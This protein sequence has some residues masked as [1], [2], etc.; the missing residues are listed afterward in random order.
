MNEDIHS[1]AGAF[2]LDALS[3]PERTRFEDHLATCDDCA[4]EVRGLREAA[5]HLGAAVAT[6]APPR[7]RAQTL[8]RIG[9]VRQLP[10][11][12]VADLGV[13]RE[14]RARRRPRFAFSLAAA[15]LVI[16]LISGVFAIR[17]QQELDRT[18]AAN[19]AVA[20]VLSSPDARTVSATA[21]TGGTATVVVSRSSGR[22]VFASSGLKPLPRSQ[23]YEL[24][25]MTSQSA[26]PAGLVRP[27]AD[28][29]TRP[30]VA[31]DLRDATQVG[32]TVEPEDGSPQPTADPILVLTL[33]A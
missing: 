6:A 19:V 22:I 17:S 11:A 33:P 30:V 4:Q 32:V 3:D 21:Q 27:G 7:L 18:R 1:L 28:G 29:R 5:S 16:A 31:G 12:V 9:E 14:R 13:A 23:T 20:R 2:A 26:R 25:L 15:C 24:W 8:A 10:P